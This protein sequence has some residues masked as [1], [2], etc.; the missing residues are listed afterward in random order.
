VTYLVDANVL[1]EPTR[2]EPRRRVLEWL[3]ANEAELAI[4]AVILGELEL[5]ILLLPAGARR[6]R[7]EQWFSRVVA[8]IECLP[9]DAEVARRWAALCARLRQAGRAMPL[10]DSLIA[11]T[12]LR[13][14]LTL[15]TRN[16]RDFAAAGVTILDPFV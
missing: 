12:A 5:G 11:A 14:D 7:L 15:V 3:T 4:D 6:Q 13:H 8:V 2:P 10:L 1:S 9:W 16:R